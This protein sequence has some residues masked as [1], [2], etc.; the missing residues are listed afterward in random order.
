MAK[1]NPY[2]KRRKFDTN[3]QEWPMDTQLDLG[4]LAADAVIKA[5]VVGFV[6]AAHLISAKLNWSAHDVP[7][8]T[9]QVTVGLCHDDY[10]IAEIAEYLVAS[11]T[12]KD[13][14]IARE[15][16]RRGR[17]I[18]RAGKFPFA[19]T[20]EVLNDGRP[21]KTKLNFDVQQSGDLAV[22][23]FNSSDTPLTGNGHINCDGPLW[24]RWK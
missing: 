1:N 18:K 20:E 16:S 13:D 22:W 17:W 8:S 15:R 21:I 4:T 24:G 11:P 3:F 23:A 14:K 6:D 9:G 12:T 10:T 5:N 2:R 19:A 7:T